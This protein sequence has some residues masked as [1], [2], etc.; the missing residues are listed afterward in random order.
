[1]APLAI[2]GA[3]FRFFLGHL[4]T[5]LG[6]LGPSWDYLGTLAGNLG[7]IWGFSWDYLGA[8]WGHLGVILG[9]SWGHLGHLRTHIGLMLA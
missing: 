5:I 1:M 2:S 7:A 8:I 6:R 4:V 9:L 3:I